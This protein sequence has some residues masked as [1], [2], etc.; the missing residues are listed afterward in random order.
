MLR[1]LLHTLSLSAVALVFATAAAGGTGPGRKAPPANTALPAISGT[2]QTGKTMTAT[3]GTWSGQTSGFAF[4]WL[5]CDSAGAACASIP[6]QTA[7]T[8]LIAASEAGS[9]LRVAV[10]ALSRNGSALATSAATALITVPASPP[11]PPPPT[12]QNGRFGFAAGGNI[13]NLSAAELARYLDGAKAAHTGWIRIDINWAVVQ[14]DG[15]SSYNWTPFDNVV[16]ATTSRGMKVLAGILYTPGWARPAGTAANT[17]PSDLS[18]YG[19][20]ASAAVARYAPM[21][22]HAYEVWNEPNI[23][24]FWAPGPDPAPLHTTAQARVHGD[25][26]RRRDG[27]GRQRRSLALWSIRR[28]D[29][30]RMN[31]VSFLEQMYAN[32]AA[33][34]FDAVG[35]HPYNYPWGLSYATWSAWS[36]MAQTT[37]SARSLMLARGD[38][39]KQIWATEFGAPTGT[40]TRDVSEASQ[41]K[42]VTDSYTQLK[43]WSW[44]GP[45]FFYS[46]H[47]NG[48]NTT[49]VEQNFGIVRYDWTPK[50]AYAAYQSAAAAG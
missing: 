26:G 36:Q 10:T 23:V 12:Q 33:G 18:A 21:G 15:A 46:Y 20:F 6:G 30:Q 39:A 31:P 38:G 25:Q 3:T 17:P 40:T 44:A 5:R 16:R 48:T 29:W 9:T 45:G 34:S 35:W 43:S 32:G 11:P 49:D 4:Q 47:D 22:V 1:R 37:P 24:N 7:S 41:A 27:N 19:R 8:H 42:L 28:E 13:Q 50:L 2:A 14:A